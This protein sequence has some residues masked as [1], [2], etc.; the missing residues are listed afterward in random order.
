[1]GKG[2]L[3]RGELGW[4]EVVGHETARDEARLCDAMRGV[5][6]EVRKIGLRRGSWVK[7]IGT[8]GMHLAR[9]V[10]SSVWQRLGC[11]SPVSGSLRRRALY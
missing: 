9:S 7:G 4:S 10:Q 5:K 2:G 11:Q 6:I 1:M 8:D 3:Q